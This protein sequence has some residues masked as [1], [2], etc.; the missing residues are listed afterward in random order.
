MDGVET[1]QIEEYKALRAEILF[2]VRQ[3]YIF[4]ATV[5]VG[6]GAIYSWLFSNTT[7]SI[8]EVAWWLSFGIAILGII[9]EAGIRIRLLQ[10]SSYIT[11]L[12]DTFVTVSVGG[13]ENH[14]NAIRRSPL[15][16]ILGI[17]SILIWVSTV[18]VTFLIAFGIF[19]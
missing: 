12:E 16:I 9:R 3:S 17:S 4:E 11:K 1:F 10:L 18:L 7:K 8:N 5:F 15:S 14:L 6:L 19:R 13:W 2:L